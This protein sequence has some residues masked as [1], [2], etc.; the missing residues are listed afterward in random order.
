MTDIT[1]KD[2][3]VPGDGPEPGEKTWS[4]AELTAEFDVEGFGAPF[5]AVRRKSDGVRGSLKFTHSPRVYYRFE[6]A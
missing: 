6:P 3:G 4:I 5:V 2:Y 1:I